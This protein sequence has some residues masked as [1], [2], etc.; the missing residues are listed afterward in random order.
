MSG[1]LSTKFYHMTSEKTSA[2]RAVIFDLDGTLVDSM[3]LVLR[4]FAYALAPFRPDLGIEDIFLRLGGPPARLL[5][6]LTGDDEQAAEAIR[7]FD[8]FGFSDGSL[9]QPFAGMLGMLEHLQARGL[10]MGVWTGRDRRTTQAILDAH[11][12]GRFFNVVVCGDDLPTHKPHPEGLVAILR[13]L[14]TVPGAALYAGDAEADVL[15]GAAAGVC[16][17][18]ISHG[19]KIDPEVGRRAWRMVENPSE[20]YAV[21]MDTVDLTG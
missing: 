6:E 13:G 17:V 4:A 10:V 7:R 19:R 21:I 2:L 14:A 20:A 5:R 8:S 9:V 11:N 3:P 18:M 16:T 1:V 15:G 12:L